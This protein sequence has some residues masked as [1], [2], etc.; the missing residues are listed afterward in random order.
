VSVDGSTPA[1]R[2]A[3]A[4]P[5]PATKATQR[6]RLRLAVVGVVI[7]GAVGFLLVKGLGSSLDY[8]KT[9]REASAQKAQLGT[10]TFR[11]EGVVEPGSV[12]RT[13]NGASFVVTQGAEGF[14]VINVGTPP[15]LFKATLPV[16]VVGH[17]ASATS[18]TFLSNQI[19]VKHTSSYIAAHPNR[20]RAGDGTT[21]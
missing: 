8:F 19:M 3:P 2:P 10:S 14:H 7:L 13:S 16:I 4:A 9:V 6:P 20:V 5:S 21:N 11:L 1:A 18:S 15:Q 12:T 17:F